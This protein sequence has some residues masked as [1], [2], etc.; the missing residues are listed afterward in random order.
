MDI[1]G[2]GE[3]DGV[4]GTGTAFQD[5]IGGVATP[6]FTPVGGTGFTPGVNAAG[7]IY[8]PIGTRGSDT[9]L[10]V[11]GVNYSRVF[12]AV[13]QQSDLVLQVYSLPAATAFTFAEFGNDVA[14]AAGANLV[15]SV[16]VPSPAA[17]SGATV[18]FS[19]VFDIS[20]IGANDPVYLRFTGVTG[21]AYVDNISATSVPEP[22]AFLLLGAGCV[23]LFARRRRA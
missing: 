3:S 14:T 11:A 1:A 13:G 20:T 10:T 9:S 18:A 4:I 17:N 12:G 2:W 6:S 16:T 15:G 22:S 23:G 7:F 8:S 21:P 5:F 19:E